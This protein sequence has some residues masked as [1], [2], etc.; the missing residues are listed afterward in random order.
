MENLS[1]VISFS[2]VIL[3]GYFLTRMA[4]SIG[5]NLVNGRQL[6]R[7]LRN[8]LAELPLE[9]ALER[10]G[11]DPDIYLHTRQLHEI[12]REMRNCGDCAA[13]QQCQSALDTAV[14]IEKFVFCP[15][16]ELLFKASD[17]AAR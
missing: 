4:W 6:R 16:Y 17:R 14:P 10:A 12:D 11:T 1:L 8:R 13:V 15:N 2:F 9:H 5:T 7:G 3:F